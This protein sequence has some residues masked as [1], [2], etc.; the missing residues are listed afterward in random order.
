MASDFDLSREV[1]CDRF[2]AF[3]ICW[4]SG[5]PLAATH[6]HGALHSFATAHCNR[7]A[8]LRVSGETAGRFSR[9]CA[10]AHILAMTLVPTPTATLRRLPR[11]LGDLQSL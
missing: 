11:C 4:R 1:N 7:C 9:Q 5:C 2:T 10:S 8:A 3:S 6:M